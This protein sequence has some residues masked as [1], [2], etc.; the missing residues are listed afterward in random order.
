MHVKGGNPRFYIHCNPCTLNLLCYLR[1][2]THKETDHRASVLPR[3]GLWGHRAGMAPLLILMNPGQ[4]YSIQVKPEFLG[5]LENHSNCL[6]TQVYRARSWITQT[7]PLDGWNSGPSW[8]PSWHSWE[9]SSLIKSQMAHDQPIFHST[10]NSQNIFFSTWSI[11]DLQCCVN[12][13]CTAKWF[14]YTHTHTH[15][16]SFKIFFSSTQDTEYSAVFPTEYSAI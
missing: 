9:L 7:W 10:M 11:V 1:Y 8:E 12:F 15:I 14:S 5:C 3:P 13:C 16:Y 2:F 6:R 4:T